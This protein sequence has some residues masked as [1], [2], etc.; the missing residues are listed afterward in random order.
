[1]VMPLCGEKEYVD[2]Y[3]HTYI[4]C[5]NMIVVSIVNASKMMAILIISS[6]FRLDDQCIAFEPSPD[7]RAV[8]CLILRDE[9]H[10]RHVC[11]LRTA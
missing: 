11:S 7:P 1:M 2:A 6:Q 10:F 3:I 9:L 5:F 4:Q 8:S